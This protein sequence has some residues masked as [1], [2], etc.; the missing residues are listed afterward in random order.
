MPGISPFKKSVNAFI[1]SFVLVNSTS[2]ISSL[3]PQNFGGSNGPSLSAGSS[4]KTALKISVVL[5]DSDP[6]IVAQSKYN[7]RL[8]I[9]SYW[10]TSGF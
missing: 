5:A 10:M 7:V 2:N 1:S 8:E 6:H 9:H 3:Y 4:M